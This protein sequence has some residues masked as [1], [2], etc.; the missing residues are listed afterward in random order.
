MRSTTRLEETMTISHL[1]I[2]FFLAVSG[3][4]CLWAGHLEIA[5]VL[6]ALELLLV[7]W[8]RDRRNHPTLPEW[9]EM[10]IRADVK[11]REEMLKEVRKEKHD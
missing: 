7:A 1:L 9:M 11:K 2:I 6:I 10:F 4:I 8:G 3:I 5:I